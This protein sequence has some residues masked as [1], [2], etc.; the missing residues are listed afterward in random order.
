MY[1][2]LICR[3]CLCNRRNGAGDESGHRFPAPVA[4]DGQ[5]SPKIKNGRSGLQC[6]S[7][8]IYSA[9][10]RQPVLLIEQVTRTFVAPP[11]D[12]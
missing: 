12:R 11:P 2:E 6:A 10:M 8:N 3:I 1:V 7:M 4:V 9:A 5:K